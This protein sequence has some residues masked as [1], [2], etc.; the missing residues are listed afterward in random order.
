MT[1]RSPKSNSQGFTL[2]EMITT[3]AVAGVIMGIAVPSFL[4]LNKPLR[5][6]SLQFKSQLS[7]I[8]SKAISSNRAYRLKPK[9][10]T[11]SG[12]PDGKARNFVVEYAANC[13]VTAMGGTNGW[14][15]ASE[16]DLDLPSNVGITSTPSVTIAS[17]AG[18]GTVSNSL[19]WN[20]GKGICFDNRGLVDDT[21]TRVVLQDFQGNNS[22]KLA[23]LDISKIGNVD[24]YTY[25]NA[26]ASPT[27]IPLS[28]DNPQF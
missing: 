11:L 17:P 9:F 16:F 25:K 14:Q 19:N 3:L 2:I 12:Y 28:Q 8:R 6:G 21:T 10:S 23:V 20:G 1:I 15:A 26:T 22:A 5:E 13:R 24:I 7:L 18:I 27:Q 4:S